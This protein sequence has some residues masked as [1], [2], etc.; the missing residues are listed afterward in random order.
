MLLGPLAASILGNVLSRNR[1]MGTG[2]EV[3]RAGQNF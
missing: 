1:V 2:E 3:V